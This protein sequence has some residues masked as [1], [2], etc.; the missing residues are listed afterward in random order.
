LSCYTRKE[1]RKKIFLNVKTY[2]N[3]GQ[4]WCLMPVILAP[5]EAEVE[6]MVI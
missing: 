3:E 1:N 2:T 4:T 6:R 5:W